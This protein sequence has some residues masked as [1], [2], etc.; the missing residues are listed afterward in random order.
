MALVIAPFHRHKLACR[1]I[2]QEIFSPPA[3]A[4]AEIFGWPVSRGS[5][6]RSPLA[7]LP[8]LRSE[9]PFRSS[10][11]APYSE[12]PS[13]NS[14]GSTALANLR[15]SFEMY[16]TPGKSM[17]EA[18][19]QSPVPKANFTEQQSCNQRL[20]DSSRLRGKHCPKIHHEDT[21]NHEG[22]SM[23][24]LVDGPTGWRP[25]PHEIKRARR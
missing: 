22:F 6:K 20:G 14:R 7:K 8:P 25:W 18:L 23:S 16:K 24:L 19:S 5:Q 10:S 21:K 3:P 17:T 4:G 15:A 2:C 9:T 1:G 13:P 11:S 12:Q